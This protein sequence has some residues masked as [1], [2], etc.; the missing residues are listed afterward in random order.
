MAAWRKP[1]I[2][3]LTP[4]TGTQNDAVRAYR[5]SSLVITPNKGDYYVLPAAALEQFRATPAQQQRIDA[6]VR[7]EGTGFYSGATAAEKSARPDFASEGDT[8][9]RAQFEDL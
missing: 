5:R 3:V 1:A 8:T 2:T 9:A 7:D 4:R 6:L